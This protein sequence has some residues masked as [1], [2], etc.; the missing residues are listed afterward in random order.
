M[1]MRNNA[2]W[3][4]KNPYQGSA[5]KV[6]CICSA[7]LLRSPSIAAVLT[8]KGYNTRAAGVHDYALIQVDEVLLE[9]ADVILF[10]DRGHY[11]VCKNLFPEYIENTDNYVLAIPDKYGY[12]DEELVGI[13]ENKLKEI[14]ID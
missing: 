8:K 11:S 10:A 14:K 6:L 13:I 7:G 1:L 9:W 4:C 3:N 12:M 2:L 5:K